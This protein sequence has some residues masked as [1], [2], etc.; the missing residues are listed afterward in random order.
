MEIKL[1]KYMNF[2]NVFQMQ[3]FASATFP[4]TQYFEILYA[5]IQPGFQTGVGNNATYW[6][7]LIITDK[8]DL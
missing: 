7:Q 5:F 8:F 3:S 6:M 4:C 1:D 2:I